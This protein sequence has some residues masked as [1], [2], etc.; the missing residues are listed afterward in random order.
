MPRPLYPN[1][2][3]LLG[4]G[5]ISERT[6][7][8]TSKTRLTLLGIAA[9]I[10]LALLIAPQTRWLVRM[11]IFPLSLLPGRYDAQVRAYV[12]AHPNDY[13]IQLA[14]MP[15]N[16]PADPSANPRLAYDRSLVPRFPNSA[17]LRANILRYA[18]AYEVTLNRDEDYLLGN[19]PVPPHHAD[20]L[21]PP[22]TPAHLAAFDA[23]AAA[24]ERLDPDNAYFPFMRA[25][26]LFAA[27][28][29]AEALV[30]VQRASQKHVWREYYDDEI[31][32][33]WRIN[34]A[35]YGGQEAL[36]A[37]AVSASELFPQY[38]HLRAL[39]RIV[40]W[41][42]ILDEKAGHPEA[43]LAKREAL[44]RCGEIMAVHSTTLIGNLVG[45]AINAIS[46]SRPGG[47]SAPKSDPSVTGEQQAQKRL[48]AYC[49]YVTK[50]GHPEAAAEAE[51]DYQTGQQIRHTITTPNLENFV[52]GIGER[53]LRRL[54]AALLAGGTLLPNILG[55]LIAGLIAAGLSRL[56]RF[57][58][59]TPLPTGAEF[60]FWSVLILG[61]PLAAI[62]AGGDG[63]TFQFFAILL[64]FLPLCAAAGVALF[65]PHLRRSAATALLSAGVTLGAL[66][67]L[68]ALAEWQMHGMND[69]A[70][71][72]RTL[73]V[74]DNDTNNGG[75]F[76]DKTVLVQ[77][78]L[79]YALGLAVPLLT[80]IIL[81][82]VSRVKRVPVSVGLVNG[83]RAV[84]P[85][86]VCCLML[87]YGGLAL[88]TVRQ[89]ARANYGLE[90]SLHGE[91]QYLAE[92]TG[93]AW[94]KEE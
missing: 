3:P 78:L 45:I 42:A 79:I 32:G 74:Q 34:D 36:S 46:R 58:R 57:Q 81:S 20:P 10:L 35:V 17:S 43:G 50:V 53:G 93:Q 5:G 18:T 49:A 11:Q 82:I 86:L 61:L 63:S 56:P 15:D 69:F 6:F 54:A 2:S 29:D 40:V 27:H 88:W 51:A 90:R 23:D 64:I 9:G 30:E 41:K 73:Y 47:G 22:P 21:R 67:L 14:G 72:L 85:P 19:L 1:C 16:S 68:A 65:R 31:E 4:T 25:F 76:G 70:G 24:G 37:G 26:G 55:V 84:M 83:F 92:I 94:P 59:L 12:A 52:L 48:E 60:G 75:M 87:V 89:E 77:T 8:N 66:S 80:A 38:Q 71:L 7:M 44:G 33:R 91:G 62:F 39:A 28:R 13:Q